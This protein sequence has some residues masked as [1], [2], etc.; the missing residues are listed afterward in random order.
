MGKSL[1][2][3]NLPL[4]YLWWHYTLAWGDLLRLY[5][6]FSWFLWNFF[7]IPLLAGTLFSP[8]RRLRESSARGS[9]GFLGSF[10]INLILRFVGL[11]ARLFT[12]LFGLASLALFAVLFLCFLVL[13]PFLP[14]IA[15]ASLV[16]GVAPVLTL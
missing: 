9:G 3:F 14:L 12:I 2:S 7:S 4:A 13:W 16:T 11:F 6:N 5:K 1:V 10:I 8:W 15:A